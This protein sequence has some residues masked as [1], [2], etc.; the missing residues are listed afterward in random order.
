MYIYVCICTK[1]KF[2]NFQK[3]NRAS[4]FTKL[5][6]IILSNTVYCQFLYLCISI[7][8]AFI[9]TRQRL[10]LFFSLLPFLFLKYV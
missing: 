10:C 3:N 6:L 5:H 2:I 4:M 1:Q 9:F 7:L 8:N